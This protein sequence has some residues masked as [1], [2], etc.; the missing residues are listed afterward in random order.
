MTSNVGS[1]HIQS[2]SGNNGRGKFGL[3]SLTKSD[4]NQKQDEI[5]EA[6]EESLRRRFL[7]EFLNRIDETIIFHPL[8]KEQL[9]S[10]V[11][12]QVVELGQRL[13]EQGLTLQITEAARDQIAAEGYDPVYGARPLRRTI[14]QKLENPLSA[15]LL[16]DTFDDGDTLI[17]DYVDRQFTFTCAGEDAGRDQELTP[18]TSS[19]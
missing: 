4:E 16:K 5:R 3:Q 18:V 2:I 14:Q 15:E 19:A 11:D 17:V 10:I 7:P 13:A 12:L 8:Q 1:Q 9:R 6:V